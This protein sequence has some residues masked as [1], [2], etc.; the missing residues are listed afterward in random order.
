MV[1]LRKDIKILILEESTEDI[2]KLWNLLSENGFTT[3]P[4]ISQ[5]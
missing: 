4:L 5:R 1:E 3:P 2:E